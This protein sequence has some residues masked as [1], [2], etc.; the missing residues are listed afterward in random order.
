MQHSHQG[1]QLHKTMAGLPT[2]HLMCVRSL[3][4]KVLGVS[5]LGGMAAIVWKRTPL[6]TS[7]STLSPSSPLRASFSTYVCRMQGR[8]AG[9]CLK[10]WGA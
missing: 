6:S 7:S 2:P 5:A 10:Q 1:Q 9:Q 4:V 3:R 8:E